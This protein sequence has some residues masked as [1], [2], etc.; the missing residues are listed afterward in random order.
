MAHRDEVDLLHALQDLIRGDGVRRAS[1]ELTWD[2]RDVTGLFLQMLAAEGFTETSV[3]DIPVQPG[4][5][6]PAFHVADWT[7]HFGWVF[8][9]VFSA[10]RK[11]K[12]FGSHRK[13]EKG[14]WAI[15]LARRARVY[16]APSRRELMDVDLPS[17]I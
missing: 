11:R 13:N 17:A 3:E 4:E 7:A 5:R 8:W 16:A 12:I 2:G 10:D 6:I 9:E 14:D 15:T 1:H